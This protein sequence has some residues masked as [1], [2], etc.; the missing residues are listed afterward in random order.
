MPHS[1]A[2]VQDIWRKT[3]SI[4]CF[5]Q[6]ENSKSSYINYKQQFLAAYKTK[7][8]VNTDKRKKNTQAFWRPNIVELVY[9][10]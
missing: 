1:I 5:R 2:K 9:S 4:I 8:T 6:Q 7:S 3:P 10:G